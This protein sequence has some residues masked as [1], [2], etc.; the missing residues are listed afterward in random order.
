MLANKKIEYAIG[1]SLSIS[2]VFIPGTKNLSTNHAEATAIQYLLKPL[3]NVL[4]WLSPGNVT[5]TSKNAIRNIGKN[6]LMIFI[7]L[8]FFYLISLSL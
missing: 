7:V 8:S 4:N 3:A 6:V 5:A 2:C 1:L